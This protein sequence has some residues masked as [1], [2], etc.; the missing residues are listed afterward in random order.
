MLDN[1]NNI[2]LLPNVWQ[3][4]ILVQTPGLLSCDKQSDSTF[5][6]IF[7]KKKQVPVPANVNIAIITNCSTLV[8]DILM[9]TPCQS[10]QYQ[11]TD[12]FPLLSFS[13]TVSDFQCWLEILNFLPIIIFAW[14]GLGWDWSEPSQAEDNCCGIGLVLSREFSSPGILSHF[15][16]FLANISRNKYI[17]RTSQSLYTSLPSKDDGFDGF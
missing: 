10:D 3:F 14:L 11:L 2:I 6:F 15:K 16:T 1:N 4:V 8:E 5:L 17:Y 7:G 13:S 9:V 12:L